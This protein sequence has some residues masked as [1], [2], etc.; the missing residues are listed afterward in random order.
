MVAGIKQYGLPSINFAIHTLQ[1]VIKDG[2]LAQ[3][4][5]SDMLARCQ[6]NVSHYKHPH[7]A[8]ERLQDIRTTSTWFT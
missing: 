7:L 3:R 8:V 5:V 2:I 4:S 1:L 6:K